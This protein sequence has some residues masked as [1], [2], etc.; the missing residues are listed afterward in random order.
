[1]TV[2]PAIVRELRAA[3]RQPFTFTLRTLGVA[4]LML[5]CFV[6]GLQHGFG[7]TLGGRLFASL[8]FTLFWAIWLLVP[9]LTADC[10]SR[11]RR[12]GT[13]GLLFLTQLNARDIVVAKTL[14]HVLRALTLWLSVLPVLAIPF[15]LGGVSWMEVLLSTTVNFSGICWALAAG[16]LA[17]AWTKSWLRSV[18]G[19]L[20]LAIFLLVAFGMLVGEVMLRGSSGS[21]GSRSWQ[22]N[23]DYVWLTGLGLIAGAT[24]YI[25][26]AFSPSA[27]QL[28]Q[29]MGLLSGFSVLGLA[30]A[31]LIAASRTRRVWQEVPPSKAQLWWEKTF[32]TP[33]F[34][35]AFFRSWMRRKLERNPVGWLEQR[36][37]TGRLVT[38]GWLAVVISIYSAVLTD[39]YFL[40]SSSSIQNTMAW[41]LTGSLAMTAASSFRRERETGVM[42]LLLVSPLGEAEIIWGRL[43]GLWGQFLPAFGLL[44]GIW[45]YFS[46][47]LSH[48]EDTGK[49]FVHAISFLTLPVVGLYFSLRC[50][51]FIAAFLFTLAVGLLAPILLAAF[52]RFVAW[53]YGPGYYG[54]PVEVGALFFGSSLIQMTLAAICARGLYERLKRRAFRFIRD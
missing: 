39:R 18:L 44:L 2:S 29:A 5:A 12:E 22:T 42:E 15:L 28:V 16:L 33:I 25:R 36:R 52:F 4:A 38:W 53:A 37:W 10:I 48:H 19:G 43:R 26:F 7:P 11:E 30:L 40:R 46:A 6:F 31:I 24:S 49:I 20:L 32:C 50:G 17:S 51:N 23:S 14:V 34:W 47:L 21:P 1:M 45:A 3:A 27:K 41:L 35:L 8:H 13:L 9:L 54:G